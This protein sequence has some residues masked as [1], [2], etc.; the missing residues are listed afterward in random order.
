[1]PTRVGRRRR[2]RQAGST[3]TI[4]PLCRVGRSS[5]DGR[6]RCRSVESHRNERSIRSERYTCVCT[7]EETLSARCFSPQRVCVW[8][9]W[10]SNV[11]IV[12]RSVTC[13]AMKVRSSP[14][15]ERP[16]ECVCPRSHPRA[17]V[18][19]ERLC[20]RRD[21]LIDRFICR[22]R[23][24]SPANKGSRPPWRTVEL[25]AQVKIRSSLLARPAQVQVNF[26]EIE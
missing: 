12:Q 10:R 2:G 8:Q 7:Y 15:G 18:T 17:G 16:G 24:W 22:H 13:C 11:S 14:N 21:H 3:Q 6:R 25:G 20:E 5:A 4:C 23:A 1:M 19:G 9:Q 26:G